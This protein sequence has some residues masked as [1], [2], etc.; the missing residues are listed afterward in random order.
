MHPQKWERAF[1]VMF[2]Q[3]SYLK[4]EKRYESHPC[5]GGG[6]N[7]STVTL[8]V[9][10]GDGKGSHKSETVKYGHQY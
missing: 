4:D 7:T 9:V 6:A 10:G 2:V 3:R 8:R 1:L 5:V